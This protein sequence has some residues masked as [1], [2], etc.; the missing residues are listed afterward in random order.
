MIEEQGVYLNPEGVFYN[1]IMRCNR[2][3]SV[4]VLEAFVRSS[5]KELT[6]CDAMSGCGVRGL[7]YYEIEGIKK[8]VLNDKNPS[9]Y[10]KIKENIKLNGFLLERFEVYNEDANVILAKMKFDFIDLDPFGSPV[11]F[12]DSAV[13]SLRA[14]GLIGLTA[15]DLPVTCGHYPNT[16]LRR[17]N[18]LPLKTS[19]CHESSLRIY[20]KATFEAFARHDRCFILLLAYYDRHYVRIFGRMMESKS[21]ADR[22]FK[23]IGYI[24]H[25][26][27]GFREMGKGES[28]KGECPTCGRRLFH[29]GPLWASQLG[30]KGFIEKVKVI[31][32]AKGYKE[33]YHIVKLLSEELE[34]L[35]P[36]YDTHHLARRAR[37][38]APKLERFIKLLRKEGY[39]AQRTHFSSRGLR[40]DCPLERLLAYLK[41]NK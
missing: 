38:D 31:L 29:I 32:A 4:A 20:V 2:D 21:L 34:I 26:R 39:L 33:A 6:V 24:S 7:R 10:R 36:Y 23:E 5:N 41:S 3:I 18:S 12:L 15:T 1:P 22:Y 19:Y 28:K 11:P 9:A 40:T 35:V 13:R 16:C 25:C 37:S 8:I 30:E 27:C 17:Y 14:G